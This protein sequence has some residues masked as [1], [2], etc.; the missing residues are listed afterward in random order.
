MESISGL[1]YKELYQAADKSSL[2]LPQ[3][4]NFFDINIGN[5]QDKLTEKDKPSET[6]KI[7]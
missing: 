3:A 6:K 2:A 1:L 5:I 7:K 4:L